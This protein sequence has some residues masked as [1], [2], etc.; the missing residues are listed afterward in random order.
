M[1]E[2]PIKL[3]ASWSELDDGQLAMV[4]RLIARELTAPEIQTICLIRWN[5]L[6]VIGQTDDKHFYWIKYMRQVHRVSAR[7][8]QQ[9]ASEMAFIENV[10][11]APVRLSRIGKHLPLAADFN[12]VPFEIF[13]YGE[14]LYQGYLHTENLELLQELV[15]IL[16]QS[17]DIKP[18]RYHCLMAFYWFAALK[19]MFARQFTHFFQPIESVQD[20]NLLQNKSLYQKLRDTMNAQIRALTGGDITKEPTILK[21]DTWRALTE[22]DAKAEEVENLKKQK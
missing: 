20:A 7:Q 18:E 8:I 16:Y 1:A 21:M 17:D 9:A 2:I 19:T 4:F 5:K 13:L 15:Q 3:P 14:N 22:L 10:P 6:K 12:E 11:D